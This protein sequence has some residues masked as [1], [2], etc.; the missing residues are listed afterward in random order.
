MKKSVYITQ[1]KKHPISSFPKKTW[2]RAAPQGSRNVAEAKPRK[3]LKKWVGQPLLLVHYH[4]PLKPAAVAISQKNTLCVFRCFERYPNSP[5]KGKN[6]YPLFSLELVDYQFQD[7]WV[8]DTP[9]TQTSSNIHIFF[10][11]FWFAITTPIWN[12][13]WPWIFSDVC[14]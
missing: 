1:H 12:S 9:K 11:W 6:K 14:V 13:F 5:N 4:Y 8:G 2:W 10:G 3:R 7:P